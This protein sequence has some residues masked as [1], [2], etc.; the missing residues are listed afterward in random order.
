VNDIYTIEKTFTFSASHQLTH[1]PST[2]Q[3][4]RLHGH[5][6]KIVVVLE[7]STLDEQG[8]VVDYGKLDVLRD[9]IKECWDHRH[10]NDVMN[11]RKTTAEK[12]A[13]HFYGWTKSRWSQVVAVR[14]SETENTWAEYRG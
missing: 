9:Y 14:V 3:C 11:T 7:A 4:S 8:F 1:L 12:I 5:N 10:L 6:Y 2:H 13:F